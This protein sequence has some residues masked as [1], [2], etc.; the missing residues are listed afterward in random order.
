VIAP[1]TGNNAELGEEMRNGITLALEEQ[2]NK[3]KIEL[4][5]IY[6][7]DQL[8]LRQTNLAALRLMQLEKV[9]VIISVWTPAANLIATRIE[10]AHVIQFNTGWDTSVTEKSKWT[11]THGGDLREYAKMSVECMKIAHTKRLA[12]A[13]LQHLGNV[14]V[15]EAAMPLIKEAGIQVVF[16]ER[17][18]PGER[19]FRTYVLKI[20]ETKPDFVWMLALPPEDTILLR[21][22]KEMDLLWPATGYFDY[23]NPE[24]YKYLEGDIFPQLFPKE[25]Y[26]QKYTKRFGHAP[27]LVEAGHCYDMINIISDSANALYKKLG[28]VPTNEELLVELKRAR[29]LPDLT[30]GPGAMNPAGYVETQYTLRQIK[31]GKIID[32]APAK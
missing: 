24:Y 11:L 26:I 18:V 5:T 29:P 20:R 9:N 28:R 1:L 27:K 12:I 14:K 10:S 23:T 19:D 13:A 8:E 7:D 17:Y 21:A 4:K 31:N 6:E 32:Y 22:Q 15:I 2:K 3:S 16:D 30:V 25:A